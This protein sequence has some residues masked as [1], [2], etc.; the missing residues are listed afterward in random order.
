MARVIS[1]RAFFE[2]LVFDVPQGVYEPA[3]D[4]F[5]LAD[6]SRGLTG[7]I[8]DVGT[9]CG[10]QAIAA[11]RADAL[12]V[13][14]NPLAVECSR[15]NALANNSGAKFLESDLF[16]KVPGTFDWV[17]FNPPYLPTSREERTGG[18]EDLAWNGGEDGR[19]VIDRF[20]ERAPGKVGAGGGI[21]LLLSSL[22]DSGQS[23]ELLSEK[24]F[25]CRELAREGVGSLEELFVL[26]ARR[27]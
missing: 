11:S 19:L 1:M 18:P 8:L 5:M 23:G 10:I 9:G 3:R 26:E 27:E 13:D 22:S 6:F 20:L 25:A 7:R 2:D 14:V 17:V 24:G 4:S 16:G 21:L 15:R 12:G